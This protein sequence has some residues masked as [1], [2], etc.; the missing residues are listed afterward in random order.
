MSGSEYQAVLVADPRRW[1]GSE[2][3]YWILAVATLVVLDPL[4][5][6]AALYLTSGSEANPLLAGVVHGGRWGVFVGVKAAAVGVAWAAW[7]YV[8]GWDLRR[9]VP[10]LAAALGTLAV[11]NNTVVL[12]VGGPT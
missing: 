8:P 2:W 7:R 4:T 6:G 1:G 10:R 3:P 11:V 9:Y 12:A 5:S